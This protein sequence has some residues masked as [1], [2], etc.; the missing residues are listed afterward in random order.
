MPSRACSRFRLFQALAKRLGCLPVTT[1]AECAHVVE[2]ALATTFRYR[3]DVICVPERLAASLGQPPFLKELSPRRVIQFP[4]VAA[5]RHRICAALRTDPLVSFEDLFAQVT[6]AG[7]EFPFV[8]A[9]VCAKR[10]PAFRN[11][12]STPAAEGATAG[13]ALQGL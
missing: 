1:Q 10:T 6:G 7:P 3:D 4:H 13:A 12:S 11:L 2:I 8:D 5:Q 9:G